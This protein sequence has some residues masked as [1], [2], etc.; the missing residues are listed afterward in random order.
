MHCRERPHGYHCSC[1][2]LAEA[3][4]APAPTVRY[5]YC[6]AVLQ[7][8]WTV[9]CDH[10]CLAQPPAQQTRT[11]PEHDARDPVQAILIHNM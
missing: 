1:R 6:L 3:V 9:E 4:G 11:A 10:G 5:A 2:L 7:R 8:H